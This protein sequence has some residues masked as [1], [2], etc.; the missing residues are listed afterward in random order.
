MSCWAVLPS[1]MLCRPATLCHRGKQLQM[2]S[3]IVAPSAAPSVAATIVKLA[4]LAEEQGWVHTNAA[5]DLQRISSF[6]QQQ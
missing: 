5:G 2:C 6:L 1:V 4:L 3:S